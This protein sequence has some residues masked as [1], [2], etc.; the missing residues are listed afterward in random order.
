MLPQDARSADAVRGTN[1]AAPSASAP[2]VGVT[3]NRMISL[4]TSYERIG[5]ETSC[6][7]RST[8]THRSIFPIHPDRRHDRWGPS[9]A[10][11]P[12]K[13]HTIAARR[14]RER[15]YPPQC[16]EIGESPYDLRVAR[17]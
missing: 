4:L 15:H 9:T 10:Q 14:P 1:S 11:L 3:S 16:L 8:E 5:V 2:R 6:P 13:T 12:C 7:I 17:P